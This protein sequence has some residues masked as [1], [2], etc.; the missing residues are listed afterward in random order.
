MLFQILLFDKLPFWLLE[1]GMNDD[2]C[3]LLFY[4]YSQC[5]LNCHGLH[6]MFINEATIYVPLK[7]NLISILVSSQPL[8]CV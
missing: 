6:I 7:Y 5:R 3:T 8:D 4:F 2:L 1:E